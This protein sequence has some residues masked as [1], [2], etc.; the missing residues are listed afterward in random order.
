MA[1]EMQRQR[2]SGNPFLRHRAQ[3]RDPG[4][5]AARWWPW[6][7]TPAARARDDEK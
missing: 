1:R 2:H 6:I 3:R 5:R 4:P 7:A